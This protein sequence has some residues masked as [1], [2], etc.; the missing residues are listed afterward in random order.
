MVE[1]FTGSLFITGERADSGD[2]EG[3]EDLSDL[4]DEDDDDASVEIDDSGDYSGFI[5]FS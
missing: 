2:D 1:T 4:S 3:L 5:S